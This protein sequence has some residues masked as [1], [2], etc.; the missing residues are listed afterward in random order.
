MFKN[1]DRLKMREDYNV[2]KMGDVVIFQHYYQNDPPD[3]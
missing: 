3:D 2:L 1:G